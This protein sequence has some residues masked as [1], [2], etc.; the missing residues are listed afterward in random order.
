[1]AQA[2]DFLVKEEIIGAITDLSALNLEL[3]EHVYENV[4]DALPDKKM[5][6]VL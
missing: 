3:V 1:M 4:S 6:I 5:L 2:T